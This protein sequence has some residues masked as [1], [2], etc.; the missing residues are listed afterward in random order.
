M[1][2]FMVLLVADAALRFP[3]RSELGNLTS[4]FPTGREGPVHDR[5]DAAGR[6]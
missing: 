1:K 3:G 6:L 4:A 5:R 2:D